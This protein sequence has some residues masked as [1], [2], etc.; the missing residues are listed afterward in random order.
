MMDLVEKEVTAFDPK[1]EQSELL[2]ERESLTK[3]V[4]RTGVVALV[5]GSLLKN[6]KIDFVQKAAHNEL[7][8]AGALFGTSLLLSGDDDKGGD[9]IAASALVALGA[10]VKSAKYA[11]HLMDADKYGRVYNRFEK[12]DDIRKAITSFAIDSFDVFGERFGTNYSKGSAKVTDNSKV[13]DMLKQFGSGLIEGVSG[14]TKDYIEDYK[15]S[16]SFLNF[17]QKTSESTNR[18]AFEA[19]KGDVDF[20]LISRKMN[21]SSLELDRDE[22]GNAI[23]MLQSIPKIGKFFGENEIDARQTLKKFEKYQRLEKSTFFTDILG[24]YTKLESGALNPDFQRIIED[25]AHFLKSLQSNMYMYKSDLGGNTAATGEG[26]ANWLTDKGLGDFV[27]RYYKNDDFISIGEFNERYA[28]KAVDSVDE[29]KNH[30]Y[31]H[32]KA[33]ER[34]FESYASI[35]QNPT[36]GSIEAKEFYRE[37]NYIDILKDFAFT[38]VVQKNNKGGLNFIDHTALDG[39]LLNLNILGA[40]EKSTVAMHKIPYLGKQLSIWNPLS[41][42][43]S[44]RR[45]KEVVTNEYLN[46]HSS[47]A[48]TILDKKMYLDSMVENNKKTHNGWDRK[49]EKLA[50]DFKVKFT[51][52]AL[53]SVDED[54]EIRNKNYKNDVGYKEIYQTFKTKGFKEAAVQYTHSHANPTAFRGY[55]DDSAGGGKLKFRRVEE[56]EGYYKEGSIFS[57][58]LDKRDHGESAVLN[59]FGGK[60]KSSQFLMG[61]FGRQG[62][63]NISRMKIDNEIM[64]NYNELSIMNILSAYDLTD[65]SA[66]LLE[67][68]KKK[69]VALEVTDKMFGTSDKTIDPIALRARATMSETLF[70]EMNSGALEDATKDFLIKQGGHELFEELQ[71]IETKAF[72][73][74]RVARDDSIEAVEELQYTINKHLSQVSSKHQTESLMA[75]IEPDQG[76]VDELQFYQ[77]EVDKFAELS[78]Q[79]IASKLQAKSETI[80]EITN[81]GGLTDPRLEK[82]LE[83]A[84]VSKEGTVF[85]DAYNVALGYRYNMIAKAQQ[86]TLKEMHTSIFGEMRETEG[87]S[88]I[89]ES[90]IKEYGAT[91]LEKIKSVVFE[92]GKEFEFKHYAKFNE[93]LNEIKDH[94]MEL[95]K[96]TNKATKGFFEMAQIYKENLYLIRANDMQQH[97]YVQN[98][99]SA[100]TE[101]KTILE[102]VRRFLAVFKK[103]ELLDKG[104]HRSID[105]FMKTPISKMQDALEFIGIER[106]TTDFLGDSWVDHFK[107]FNKYRYLPIAA[108]VSGLVAA[109]ALSDVVVPDAVPIVGHGAVG[110]AANVVAGARVGMQYAAKYTGGLALMRGVDN[111]LPGLVDNGLTGWFDPLMDPEE[112]KE[113]YFE[114]KPIRVNK[115]RAWFT[116]GRQEGRGEEFGQYRPHLLYIAANRDSGIFDNK[117]EKFLREDFMPTSLLWTAADPYK[118]ER[119]MYEKYGAIFPKTEQLFKDIPIY[120]HM[121]SATLGEVIKPTQY[122]AEDEWRVG[123]NL[124]RNPSYN[125]NHTSSPEFIEFKEPNRILSAVFEGIEDIKTFSGL[126]GWFVT[127]GTEVVFGKTNPWENEVVLSSPDEY[128]G[129]AKKYQQLQLGGMFGITEPIRRLLDDTSALGSIAINPIKQHLPDWLPDYLKDRDNPYL[130]YDYGNFILPGKDFENSA[131]GLGDVKETSDLE[132]LRVLAMVAPM[133]Q[134]FTDL[135]NQAMENMESFSDKERSHVLQS[136]ALGT[137]YGRR[138]YKEITSRAKKVIDVSLTVDEVVSYNEFISDGKRYKLDG[139]EEDYNKL[140]AEVGGS[141]ALSLYKRNLSILSVGQT[142][143]FKASLDPTYGAGIDGEGDY[144]RVYNK[145]LADG[146]KTNGNFS[147]T[148]NNVI[149]SY[150]RK[151]INA[152]LGAELEKV[153][154][155]KT[156]F[157]EWSNENVQSPYFRDWDT[158]ISSFVEPLFRFSE[159]SLVSSFAFGDYTQKAYEKS[160]AIFPILPTIVRAGRI[161]GLLWDKVAG[162]KGISSEYQKETEVNDELEK[163]KNLAGYKSS[164]NLT[165]QETMKELSNTLNESD[166]TFFEGLVN[167]RNSSERAKILQYANGRMKQALNTVWNRQEDAL[168]NLQSEP[169]EERQE[170]SSV[171]YGGTYTGDQEMM[172]V[173]LKNQMG[174]Q[175]S[176]LDAKRQGLMKSYR[177]GISSSQGDLI[178]QKMY[179]K[180]NAPNV[181]VSST[182]TPNGR[183]NVVKGDE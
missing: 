65:E 3:K 64:E 142:I 172:K 95:Y 92:E 133:S 118:E 131:G 20:E 173:I 85:N 146:F 66:E 180:Y 53:D 99:L 4:L 32:K 44:E 67:T 150:F 147:S 176:K 83:M 88:E 71:G 79:I 121:L 94:D 9:V 78:T 122:V 60:G 50:G 170:S 140:T 120:G 161:K 148:G 45:I 124:M 158:P 35:K 123:K 54:Y 51:K 30:R 159:N 23:R 31:G 152:P 145:R 165:G 117:I 74:D 97:V 182:I 171:V 47:G 39:T 174:V 52:S 141:R 75:G 81:S 56:S 155:R 77:T 84:D 107:N 135:K 80:R 15:N 169:N 112:M 18:K 108:A 1:S 62:D 24:R 59:A 157:N 16:D 111:L 177:G 163:L 160:G 7:F 36:T 167:T 86:E 153:F 6:T 68:M 46:F 137:E 106:A 179:G 98:T 109:N 61:I 151:L 42:V 175:L 144:F 10:G 12:A 125:P 166:R 28:G 8:K 127:K 17:I 48:N 11:T 73:A 22:P 29:L 2:Q 149:T 154:G 89:Y 103:G 70:H 130:A 26:F 33:S 114:G 164:H 104:I 55:V 19:V 113:V 126:P 49:V 128:T 69:R 100:I 139:V 87:F 181:R 162:V 25:E 58:F 132:K 134:K 136:S 138:L 90:F 72:L 168:N 82:F 91:K 13:S 37:V 63:V 183:I 5:G 21:F 76:L 27:D 105:M 14:T 41:M 102:G 93:M 143:D 129:W 43:D 115:N 156:A 38:N 116:A 96:K 110:A 57:N 34:M 101:T 119:Q 178:K 40:L